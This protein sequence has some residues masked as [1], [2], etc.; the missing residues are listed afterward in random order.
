M[1]AQTIR[2]ML[3]TAVTELLQGA[4]F[5]GTFKCMSNPS[6][7]PV[8]AKDEPAGPR[9]EASAPMPMVRDRTEQQIRMVR[10]VGTSPHFTPAGAAAAIAKA[11]KK[12]GR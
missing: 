1:S 2:Q 5:F 12:A 10:L 8:A 11:L 7:I 3:A 6:E 4:P 9:D